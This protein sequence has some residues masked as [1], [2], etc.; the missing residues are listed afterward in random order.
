M[1]LS[2]AQEFLGNESPLEVYERIENDRLTG[3]VLYRVGEASIPGYKNADSPF[4]ELSYIVPE[5]SKEEEEKLSDVLKNIN[6]S[7]YALHPVTDASLKRMGLNTIITIPFAGTR[8]SR[9]LE[10]ISRVNE[11]LRFQDYENSKARFYR[12][13]KESKAKT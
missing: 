5:F 7:S 6:K 10:N 8:Q 12:E 11:V 9:N 1:A 13:S 3:L 2:K 4:L